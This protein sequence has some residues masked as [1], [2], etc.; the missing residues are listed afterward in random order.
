MHDVTFHTARRV[1]LSSTDGRP[2][3]VQMDGDPG[4]HLPGEVEIVPGGIRVLT[5]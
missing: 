5:P 2:V 4:G 1:R 3:P